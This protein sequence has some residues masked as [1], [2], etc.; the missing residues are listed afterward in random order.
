MV[1][2]GPLTAT[3]AIFVVECPR[4]AVRRPFRHCPAYRNPSRGSRIADKERNIPILWNTLS[5]RLSGIFVA[6]LVT[7]A[8]AVGYLFDRGRAEAVEKRAFEHLRLHAERGADEVARLVSQLQEDVVFLAGTPPI[9]GIRRALES[10]GLDRTGGSTLAQWQERLHQIFLSFAEARPEYFQI[11]L[12]GV[13]DNG[14]EIVRVEKIA[15]GPRVTPSASLQQKGD[16]YYFREAS[17]LGPGAVYLSRIDLNREHG[18]ISIPHL[19]TL[20]A[21]TAVHDP[22]GD[23]FGI[24]IVNMSMEWAFAR[25]ASFNDATESLYIADGDGNLLVHPVPGRAFAFEFGEPFLLAS[26]FPADAEQISAA[27]SRG[28]TFL[29]L[30]G[31]EADRLGYIATRSLGG[32]DAP[33]HLA[34]ILAEPRDAVLDGA[35]VMQR[36]SLLGMGSLLALAIVVVIFMV[37][38]LTRSLSALA[39]ASRAIA[40]GRYQLELPVAAGG[41]VG[42][43]ALAFQRMAAEVAHREADLVELNRDLERRVAERA[44]ELTRQHALQQLILE[45]I[46]DGIVVAD[47]DGR[48]LL[49]NRK[50]EQIVGSGPSAVTTENW[51]THFGVYRGEDREPVPA[52]ELPLVRA[53]NGES[54]D[55]VE[56]YL[57]N[58]GSSDGRWAQ[59]TTRPLLDADGEV[60]GGVAVMLDVTE[61]KRLRRRLE[62]QRAEL[63]EVGRMALSA[64]IASA[65][66]HQLSQP[67]AAMT[68]YASAAAR[69]QQ[70]GRLP[71]NELFDLLG[72]IESLAIQTGE[73]LDRLR[74]LMS[75]RERRTGPVDVNRVA[76]SCLEFLGERIDR[77]GV[78]VRRYYGHGLPEP[79]A[80][81]VELAQVLIQLVANALEAMEDPNIETRRVTI[82][83]R[84]EPAAG[85]VVIEVADTGPGV[86][87]DLAGR[88]FEPWQTNKPG[89]LGVGLAIAESIV[90]RHNGRI[91]LVP[92]ERGGAVF[93]VELPV[94]QGEKP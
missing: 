82:S 17:R 18:R 43:L 69:L 33:Q 76:D 42:A 22:S 81:P 19:P 31:P 41:E 73:G 88:V 14:R 3:R 12:I 93:R 60:T 66:A 62:A 11:R 13:R 4:S 91:R 89:A 57:C 28:E 36:E 71:E 8:L 80:D 15:T 32:T 68:N 72:R 29:E 63:A 35:G 37:R 45:N 86:T 59:V 77:Q 48:F 83:T 61:Q 47:R 40:E 74:G 56:L 9:H 58:P 64:E 67:I 53:I 39:G 6:V 65:A 75:R 49:W 70:Q 30:S 52:T 21:A 90:Q 44:A 92:Q 10:G 46:A 51:S 55:N 2:L 94:A 1:R 87:P 7:A 85:L 50:A 54:V 25:A 24:V 84:N 20:R 79:E 23:L 27:L 5:F 78:A 38:R 26:A 16:R 34:F